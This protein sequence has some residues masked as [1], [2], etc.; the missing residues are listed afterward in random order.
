MDRIDILGVGFDAVTCQEAVARAMAL[1]CAHKSGY[2]VTPNSEIVYAA[3]HDAALRQTLNGADL[4]LPDGIGVV[5]A[6]RILGRPIPGKVAGIEFA[7]ALMRAMAQA[8]KSVFLLGAKPGVAQQAADR[9][10]QRIPGLIVAGVKDGYFKRDE[11]AV[12]AIRQSGA[13]AAFVCLGVPKQEF[14][15]AQHLQECGV[16]FMGGFGGSL[17]VFAGVVDRAPQAW[18]DHGFEWLY[19]LKKEP[20][21]IGRMMRLPLFL[22][23]AMGARLRGE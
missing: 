9:L 15:I 18:I 3:R 12:E 8:G 21:R 5:Y 7:E 19:R 17:D 10:T 1:I 22:F 20:Q 11:E 23:A 4:V 14:F 13:D 6:S 2:A 16:S